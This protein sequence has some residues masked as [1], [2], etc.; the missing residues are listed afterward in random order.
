MNEKNDKMSKEIPKGKYIIISV[1]VG[2]ILW[3]YVPTITLSFWKAHP[4]YKPFR[5][6]VFIVSLPV[7]CVSVYYALKIS[8]NF[9]RWKREK[10]KFDEIDQTN[11]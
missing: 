1:I 7:F 2:L 10:D 5:P 6:L 9:R 4:E 8:Y 11:T 3:C